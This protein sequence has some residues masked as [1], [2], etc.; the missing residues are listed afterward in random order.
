MADQLCCAWG[1]VEDYTKAG[2]TDPTDLK[3][4]ASG[5]LLIFPHIDSCLAIIFVLK[6][7]AIGGHAAL[8]SKAGAFGFEDSL[9][10]M[11][12]R[13]ETAAKGEAPQL[14]MFVG[15]IGDNDDNTWPVNS[16]LLGRNNNGQKLTENRNQSTDVF[17]NV[18]NAMLTI[19]DYQ[20]STTGGKIVLR[21]PQSGQHVLTA[22]RKS[23]SGKCC[24]VM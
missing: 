24:I 8:T 3:A 12:N 23:I 5:D 17:Y 4:A 9:K 16:V 20:A 13:L 22:R 15:S 11:L 19:Q 1:E 18:A 6:G 10:E 21:D 14:I 7:K 2:Y